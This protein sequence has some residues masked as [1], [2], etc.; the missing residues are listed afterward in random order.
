M[1]RDLR[2]GK[3]KLLTAPAGD[4]GTGFA[5][6]A[7]LAA[8]LQFLRTYF[9]LLTFLTYYFGN[10][11]AAPSKL[12]LPQFFFLRFFEYLMYEISAAQYPFIRLLFESFSP[13]RKHLGPTALASD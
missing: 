4:Y 1:T 10:I 9:A 12:E 5:Y 6:L 13:H 2:A 7:S 3:S 8:P 11:K